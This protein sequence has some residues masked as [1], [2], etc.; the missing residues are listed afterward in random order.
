M[1]L[2]DKYINNAPIEIEIK[3]LDKIREIL[4]LIEPTSN[5]TPRMPF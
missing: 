4:D 1:E 2:I 5:H 3:V